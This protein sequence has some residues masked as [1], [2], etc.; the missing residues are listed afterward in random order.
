[1]TSP[2]IRVAP[3]IITTLCLP[4]CTSPEDDA[5]VPRPADPHFQEISAASDLGFSLA[6]GASGERY[7]PETMIGGLGWID[8]DGDGDYDLY[9]VNGHSDSPRAD[10]PGEE[11]D[12]LFRNEGEGRFVD[13]T[14]EAGLGDRRYGCGVAVGDYDGDGDSDLVVTNVGR[15]TLY[16]NDGD[17]TF[18]DVTA[19]AGLK[20][21]G[22]SSSAA[23]FDMDNDGDLDLFVARYIKYSPRFSKRCNE[24]GFIVYCHPILFQGQEDLLYRNLGGG[25]FE[26]IGRQAGIAKAGP[27]EGKGLG[28]VSFDFDRD[29]HQDVYVANDTT[30]NFLWRNKGDG[31]FEEIAFARGA[32]VSLDGKPEAG[33][34]VDV[35]DVDADGFSDIFVTNFAKE[36][37][38]L[39]LGSAAGR[40]RERNRRLGLG[41]S[42]LP[43][44]FGALFLDVELDGDPDIAILNGHVN[45]RVEETDPGEGYTYAQLPRLYVNDGSGNFRDATDQAGAFFATPCVGRG[46]ASSDFDG[47]G[48]LDL[49]AMTLDRSIV[50]LKNTTAHENHSIT[51]KLQGTR[52]NRDGYGARVTV[53]VGKRTQTFE[54]Q[55]ARSYFSACDPR[56]FVGLGSSEKADRVTVH[57]P[58]GAVQTLENVKASKKPLLIVEP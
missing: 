50:L 8:Y 41:V 18:T 43:L 25:R 14:T 19:E 46:L 24:Q 4:A 23:W 30:P 13:V 5:K 49:A 53:R 27:H 6:N 38:A 33:M 42:R 54:Y 17:G 10:Q 1:M 20:E 48:D 58:G 21:R 12:R 32:A 15:N 26:E 37:N 51:V 39:Y 57:W 9:A 22:F 3:L 2:G 36:T 34:A 16:R 29:G 45:D 47:D 52:S 44:G 56:L 7:V 28:V 31:T 11:T 55:S 40:F 35:A